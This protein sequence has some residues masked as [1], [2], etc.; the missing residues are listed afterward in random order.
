MIALF[1]TLDQQ[2]FEDAVRVVEEANKRGIFLRL[3]GAMG[4]M[5][6]ASNHEDLFLRLNRLNS[7]QKFTDIDFAA[8]GTQR[9]QVSKQLKEL[10]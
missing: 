4:I 9:T 7:Q 3:L 5:V 6:N 10:G 8:Y 1:S 2:M